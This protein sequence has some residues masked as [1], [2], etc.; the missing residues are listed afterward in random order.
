MIKETLRK[1]TSK[2]GAGASYI[3]KKVR[4]YSGK[5]CRVIKNGE[6]NSLIQRNELKIFIAYK[7]VLTLLYAFVQYPLFGYSGYY[8]DFSLVRMLVGWLAY[9]GTACVIRNKKEDIC[10]AFV[11]SI[12]L[13]SIAPFIVLYEFDAS[14]SL[15]MILI[16]VACLLLMHGV[17]SLKMKAPFAFHGISYKNGALRW[18]ATI[19]ILSYFIY[20]LWRFGLP[21]VEAF[22]F[23]DVSIVRSE[24]EL[25][26]LE[27]VM[28]N[29]AC[30]VVCP[31]YMII[32]MKEKKWA[33]FGFALLVQCYTYSVT[34]F[35][36]YLF[37]P[38]VVIGVQMIPKLSVKK[39]IL[40]GLPTG[41]TVMGL[42][43]ML[44]RSRMLYALI[45]DRMIF[46]P[47]RIKYSYFDYFSQHDF[48][49]FSQNT[50]SK[51]LGV[52]S[53]YDIPVPYL[54]GDKYFSK[55]EM[56]TNAGFMADAY[57]N[58]GIAGILL[59]AAVLVAVLM[60][61]RHGLRS[62]GK[63]L[64]KAIQSL[65]VIFFVALNDGPVISELFSGG[66]MTAVLLIL[67]IDFSEKPTHDGLTTCNNKIRKTES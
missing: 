22:S 49:R 6:L 35:K 52:R 32:A 10:T 51:L 16:Q 43:H 19:V 9:M 41:L 63:D 67:A 18:T 3:A 44:T 1:V 5:T 33:F 17:F 50:L 46:M 23:Y 27:S 53:N 13:L 30:K 42:L 28:Q 29:I 11:Y 38:L 56:W 14:Y 20:S 12:F 15:W 60:L 54:I 64:Q 7:I 48:A 66:M 39:T 65:F 62:A 58:L 4:S 8:R 37:I 25:S 47:A 59:M 36:T 61:L 40:A 57:A 34:G 21:G 2:C 45:G 26:T 55:P 31:L 24:V